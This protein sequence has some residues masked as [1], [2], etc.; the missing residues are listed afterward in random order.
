MFVLHDNSWAEMAV[1]WYTANKSLINC[2]Y[3]FLIK[4]YYL[5]KIALQL[6]LKDF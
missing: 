6:K 1:N 3:D 2:M 4:D 5:F